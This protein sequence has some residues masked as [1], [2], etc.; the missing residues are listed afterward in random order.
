MSVIN[1]TSAKDDPRA[2]WYTAAASPKLSRGLP[3]CSSATVPRM[4]KDSDR[5]WVEGYIYM[6]YSTCR[7]KVKDMLAII[8]VLLVEVN[9]HLVD[10]PRGP[11]RFCGRASGPPPDESSAL[12]PRWTSP[13]TPGPT[14]APLLQAKLYQTT[15]NLSK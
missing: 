15:H 7:G 1:A 8:I 6:L 3:S 4:P 5:V 13:E 12:G 2:H 11:C 14:A 10:T 9:L